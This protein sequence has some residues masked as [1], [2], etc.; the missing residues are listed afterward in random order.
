MRKL[1][2]TLD[3]NGFLLQTGPT[4][5]HYLATAVKAIDGRFGKGYAAKNP[6]LVST[7]LHIL[8]DDFQR[9]MA[10]AVFEDQASDFVRALELLADRVGLPAEE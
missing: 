5:E 10:H 7:M 4:G 1:T 3:A 6:A 9:S 8:A 2:G